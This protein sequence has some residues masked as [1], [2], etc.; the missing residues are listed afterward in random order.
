MDGVFI[1]VDYTCEVLVYD[2]AATHR[3][4]RPILINLSVE[5][6]KAHRESGLNGLDAVF[7]YGLA[8]R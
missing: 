2:V 3:A 1:A 6:A 8:C 4:S 5:R 7:G